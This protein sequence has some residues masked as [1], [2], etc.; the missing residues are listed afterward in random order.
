MRTTLDLLVVFAI[1]TV[2]IATLAAD[3]EADA[4]KI[5][6]LLMAPCCGANTLAMHDSGLAQQTKRE[7]REML[8]SGR[9][10]QEILDHYVAQYGNTILSMPPASGFGLAAYLLPMLVL[11]LGPLLA[12]IILR[13]RVIDVTSD[14]APLPAVDPK[15][16]ERLEGELR[17]Y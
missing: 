3:I 8:A 5:E 14:P 10:R 15:Y 9:S 17:S 12:W 16:R 4:L 1:V 2:P 11:I 13:R 7:I 6:Q